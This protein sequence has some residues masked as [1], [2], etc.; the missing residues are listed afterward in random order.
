LAKAQVGFG[1]LKRTKKSTVK[2]KAGGQYTHNYE[3][4]A[5]VIKATVKPLSENGLAVMQF[6][7]VRS[8]RQSAAIT[9]RTMLVHESGQWLYND[10]TASIYSTAPQ[11]V[12]TGQTY[13]MRYARK[14]ILGISADDDDDENKLSQ[15][16][17]S[18]E[19][20]QG[21]RLSEG[22]QPAPAARQPAKNIGR[23]MDVKDLPGG[24][25]GVCLETGFKAA[26]RDEEIA[27]AL[28]G[29]KK[30]NA[31]VELVTRASSNPKHAPIIEE[32]RIVKR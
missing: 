24:G 4:L 18:S 23:M 13:L 22:E 15:V 2:L 31:T 16:G 7:F 20:K 32:A 28:R 6:P 14:A 21:R 30:V 3:T 19:V 25:I 26:T 17:E 10:L 11:D 29:F 9:I 8:A 5:D 1:E 12:G 27:R